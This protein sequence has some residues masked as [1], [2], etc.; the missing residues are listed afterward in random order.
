M[1]LGAALRGP[2]AVPSKEDPG[3][4]IPAL[5]I[6]CVRCP[7]PDDTS[8]CSHIVAA[9]SML[10]SDRR[11][12]C[13]VYNCCTCGCCGCGCCVW[14]CCACACA[15]SCRYA[16]CSTSKFS[17]SKGIRSDRYEAMTVA[18]LAR[19]CLTNSNPIPRFAPTINTVQEESI[20]FTFSW[21]SRG[22][23]PGATRMG[24]GMD[25]DGDGI[26]E[27]SLDG[28]DLLTML[29]LVLKLALAPT[30]ALAKIVFMVKISVDVAADRMRDLSPSAAMLL[31]LVE[32]LV[33][34]CLIL[35]CSFLLVCFCLILCGA[36]GPL[37]G[38]SNTQKSSLYR[39][40]QKS[41]AS[42]KLQV[43]SQKSLG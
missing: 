43:S 20:G 28:D 41:Q 42:L 25:G 6:M 32:Y 2:R 15:C 13:I 38:S 11:S 9:F 26:V 33:D 37:V 31:L 1:T 16:Y 34:Y 19:H 30:K 39:S 35:V 36:L 17:I 14:F 27:K 29:A 4:Y 21:S 40:R 12:I 22:E 18:P 10:D 3:R 8:I 23:V 7:S 24:S 5:W